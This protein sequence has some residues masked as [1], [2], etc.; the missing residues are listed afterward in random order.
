M[1]IAYIERL[2]FNI[3]DGQTIKTTICFILLFLMNGLNATTH[4]KNIDKE[5]ISILP[6]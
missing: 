1:L 2:S 4:T 5:N 3:S 6:F